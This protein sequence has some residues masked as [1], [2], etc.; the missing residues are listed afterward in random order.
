MVSLPSTLFSQF[1]GGAVAKKT[2]KHGSLLGIT[3]DVKDLS[4]NCSEID[5][6]TRQGKQISYFD[7][8]QWPRQ[9]KTKSMKSNVVEFPDNPL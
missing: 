2:T 3:K 1:S 9:I 7:N 8:G 5:E 6:L 4:I